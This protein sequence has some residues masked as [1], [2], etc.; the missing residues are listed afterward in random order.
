MSDTL[1]QLHPYVVTIS[2]GIKFDFPY[3]CIHSVSV[4]KQRRRIRIDMVTKITAH[5]A[6]I[7]F[8]VHTALWKDG[9]FYNQGQLNETTAKQY[10]SLYLILSLYLQVNFSTT[11]MNISFAMK[12]WIT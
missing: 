6:K 11:A 1:E 5:M 4:S 8:F 12:A 7:L 2:S 3:L 10:T 9:L